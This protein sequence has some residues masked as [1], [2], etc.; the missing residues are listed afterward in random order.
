MQSRS[1]VGVTYTAMAILRQSPV[2]PPPSY[3]GRGGGGTWYRDGVER[4]VPGGC[5]GCAEGTRRGVDDD[6]DSGSQVASCFVPLPAYDCTEVWAGK[7]EEGPL[8]LSWEQRGEKQLPKVDGSG[9]QLIVLPW[10]HDAEEEV[11][12][13]GEVEDT[14][15]CERIVVTGVGGPGGDAVNEFRV[16]LLGVCF[17][18]RKGTM[19]T[20][21][22]VR[23]LG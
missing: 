19:T 4:T 10:A 1:S 11:N 14:G 2:Y 17:R 15:L 22:R 8:S 3:A 9:R 18:F 13:E 6:A 23:S 16:T 12:E 21:A 5:D 7:C 20:T